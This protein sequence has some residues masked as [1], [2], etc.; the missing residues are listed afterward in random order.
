M[1]GVPGEDLGGRT[2]DGGFNRLV[3]GAGGV[4]AT[5]LS[6]ISQA[7]S[8]VAGAG[9]A[10]DR[11]SAAIVSGDFD[12][13]GFYDLVVG[14]PGEDIGSNINTGSIAVFEGDASG[15]SISGNRRF[16]QGS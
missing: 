12:N 11:Y 6:M 3:G 9:E 15:I 4:N 1:V 5:G 7:T 16:Q 2:D 14:V 13:N 10:D 8:G